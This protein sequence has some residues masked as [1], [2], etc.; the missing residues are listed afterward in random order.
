MDE[1]KAWLQQKLGGCL[2]KKLTEENINA[3]HQAGYDNDSLSLVSRES[4]KEL[5]FP[6]A[7]VDILLAKCGTVSAGGLLS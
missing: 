3:L 2:Y 1:L 4:L 5:Q 7:I 6:L